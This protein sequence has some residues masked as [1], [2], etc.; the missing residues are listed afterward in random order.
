M[1]AVFQARQAATPDPVLLGPQ[2]HREPQDKQTNK[3]TK[4]PHYYYWIF[5]K[6]ADDIRSLRSVDD[7]RLASSS[8]SRRGTTPGAQLLVAHK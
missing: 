2:A 8:P 3:D 6:E 4:L 5:L 1:P 7:I